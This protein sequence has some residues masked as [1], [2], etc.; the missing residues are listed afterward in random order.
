M[1]RLDRL[2]EANRKN[3]LAL[4]VPVNETTPF[5][6]VTKP[7]AQCRVAIVTTA[8]M[9]RRSD[10]PFSPGEQAYRMI[11]AATPAA[12][13][14]QSHT[15]IGFDRVPTMRDVNISLPI[16]RLRELAARG[17]I[18]TAPNHYSFMG[19]LRETAKIEAETGPDVAR[20]LAADGADVALITPT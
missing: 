16:D 2:P 1:P 15:S 10:R 19:A 13:I 12:D 5:V 7:L 18:A 3:L 20:R 6:R 8:G 11:P 9:H 17:E 4:P 14:V